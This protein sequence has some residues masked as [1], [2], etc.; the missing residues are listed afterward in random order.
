MDRPGPKRDVV[1]QYLSL[2]RLALLGGLL[3]PVVTSICSRMRAP[4]IPASFYPKLIAA[5]ALAV[6]VACGLRRLER[7]FAGDIDG[8]CERQGRTLAEIPARWRPTVIFAAAALGLFLELAVLRWQAATFEIFAFY[9]N[10]GLLACFAGLGLGYALATR[11]RVLLP[12]TLPLLGVEIAVLTVTRHGLG[13][14]RLQSLFATPIHEQHSMG[15][16][17]A[18]TVWEHVAVYFLLLATFLL[19]ALAFL[20]LG[21]ACGAVME[22]EERLRAYGANLLGSLAGVLAMLALSGLWTPP[23]VWFGLSF[24]AAL[25]FQ[26]FDRR[27]L[28]AGIGAALGALTVLAWPVSFGWQQIHSPYQLLELGRGGKG[29]LTLR[30][31]GLYHQRILDLS[32]RT[33]AADPESRRLARYYEL[34][35]RVRPGP[36]DVAVVGSGMGNDVAAA[37]RSGARRVDA[38]EIDPAIL[39]LGRIHHP[40]KPYADPRVSAVVDDARSFLRNTRATYDVIAYGLLDSHTLTSHASNVRLDSFVYTVEGLREARDR[41]RP[42]GVL[43]LSFAIASS[44]IAR[45]MFLMIGEAFDGRPPVCIRARYDEAVVFLQGR[46]EAPVVPRALLQEAGFEDVT[47]V[48]ADPSLLADPSTDDWPFLYMPRRVYPL[49]YV[50][51]VG[52]ILAA[53]LA[54]CLRFLRGES[55]PG[56]PAFFFLGAG[57]MLVETKG[58]T[59]LG[60][61]F[62]NTWRVIGVVIAA[63]LV[64]AFLA[65]AAVRRLSLR[66]AWPPFLLLLASL[67]IGATISGAGGLPST[68]SGRAAAALVVTSPLFFSGI[69]FST[70][71]RS[72]GNVSGA[73]A[74]NLLGALCGGLLEY[75]SMYFGFRFLYWLAMALYAAALAARVLRPALARSHAEGGDD[76]LGLR[77]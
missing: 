49:S 50:G 43:S 35:Y 22:R 71:L 63:I 3:I 27:A 16:P 68:A 12:F 9:K 54:L 41:L 45:K 67:A 10:L 26:A 66:R 17:L 15:L 5:V 47:A 58:I 37:L 56:H 21:Q 32:A 24:A 25:A 70:M 23:A 29:P 75:N 39:E 34:A 40:E 51:V 19:T 14:R 20:P 64:M 52:L 30:A 72:G 55:R 11:G 76:A 46:D 44:D 13:A 38:V 4:G 6:L 8:L 48:Y 18:T 2:V 74:A 77:P 61:V 73:M 69:V 57:F 60:L 7:R 28:L 36:V 42:G 1:S 65:N 59:E 62:G 33:Q 31:A 53:S